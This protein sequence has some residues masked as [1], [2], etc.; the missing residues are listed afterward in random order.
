MVGSDYRINFTN[1]TMLIILNRS[2]E[3]IVGH[4]FR[5]FL[6]EE[7]TDLVADHYIRRRRGEEVPSR[8]EFNVVLKDGG[9]R[10][11]EISSTI[12][13]D[14]QGEVFTVAHVCGYY[15]KKTSRRS[16]RTK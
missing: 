11:V 15:R 13:K 12:V 14:M 3:E 16:A 6:D 4:D 8:Y 10:R 9:K 7:S 1:Q 5:E 2:E